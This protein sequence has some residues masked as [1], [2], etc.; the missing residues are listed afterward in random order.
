MLLARVALI[1]LVTWALTA[2]VPMSDTTRTVIIVIGAVLIG[3]LIV[4]SALG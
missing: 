1:G 2:L 3:I 4:L